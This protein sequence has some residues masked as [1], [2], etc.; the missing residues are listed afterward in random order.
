[1]S[2]LT[3][4]AISSCISLLE[5]MTE[6]EMLPEFCK[7]MINEVDMSEKEVVFFCTGLQFSLN[8]VGA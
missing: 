2:N 3:S 5:D 6:A 7:Y 4:A 8:R 1:M